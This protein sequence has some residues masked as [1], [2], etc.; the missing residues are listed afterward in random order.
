MVPAVARVEC[1]V[2]VEITT[3]T[4][5]GV[6]WE[7]SFAI[8]LPLLAGVII[9]LRS[10]AAFASTAMLQ[11]RRHGQANSVAKI[12]RTQSVLFKIGLCERSNVTYQE[13]PTCCMIT[14]FPRC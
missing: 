3:T 9:P 14:F 7:A 8:G 5:R 2:G 12:G 13:I 4:R 1:A 10:Y 11:R 6:R